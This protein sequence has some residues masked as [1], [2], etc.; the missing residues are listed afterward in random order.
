[1][2]YPTIIIPSLTV[3]RQ[4]SSRYQ[5]VLHSGKCPK[6]HLSSNDKPLKEQRD[7]WAELLKWQYGK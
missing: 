6:E 5:Q 4:C 3:C 1:M 2:N 7:L